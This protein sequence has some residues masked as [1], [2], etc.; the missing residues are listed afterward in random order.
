MTSAASETGAKPATAARI[1]DYFLGGTHNFPA[2]RA[3][4]QAVMKMI[5]TVQ[6]SARA[7]RAFLQRAVRCVADAGVRQFLDI[8][9]GIPTQGN[10][11]EVADGV[12]DAA[13]IVYVDVDP[14]AVSESLDI[15]EGSNSRALAVW[16]DLRDPQPILDN[17]K[18]RG[19]I[20][21]T[22][23]VALLLVATLHFLADDVAYGAVRRLVGALAPGSFL[24]IS[25]AIVPEEV[26]GSDAMRDDFRQRGEST[27]TVYRQ[28]T[29]TPMRSRS[30][31]EVAR[32]FEGL[33][34]LEPGLTWVPLWRPEATDPA[35]FA[36][37]PMLSGLLAGAGRLPKNG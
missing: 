16:G 17:S 3:A 13:R 26:A 28:S 10:V 21:F 11:H 29:A 37:N 32:F 31:S 18:V 19:L 25:H 34:V 9:S 23:P 6:A 33:E 5:P 27:S 36:D 2:D 14:V 35:D 20:D 15:L 12:I 30:Q 1:Y 8:G 24:V 22:Q 4:A 7:N